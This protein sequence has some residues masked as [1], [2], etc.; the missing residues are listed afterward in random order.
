MDMVIQ[1][2]QIECLRDKELMR[3]MVEL[4]RAGKNFDGDSNGK[5]ATVEPP[6]HCRIKKT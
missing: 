6:V 5:C 1:P 2:E 4:K 3:I